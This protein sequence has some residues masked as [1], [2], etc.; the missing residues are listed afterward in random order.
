MT[1]N[2][3][4]E[5]IQVAILEAL[6]EVCPGGS[7]RCIVQLAKSCYNALPGPHVGIEAGL[8]R[9]AV[10]DDLHGFIIDRVYLVW[11]NY[12]NGPELL[13]H[14]LG[15]CTTPCL[16]GGPSVWNTAD[17]GPEWTGYMS[18]WREEECVKKLVLFSQ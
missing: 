4:S 5:S 8:D 9:R 2:I 11:S 12:C 16:E 3:V 6:D 10:V 17:P 13:Y 18:D 7:C 1:V 14:R 15:V